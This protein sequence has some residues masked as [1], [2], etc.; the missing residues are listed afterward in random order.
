MRRGR[1]GDGRRRS[2]RT[3]AGVDVERDDR[4]RRRPTRSAIAVALPPGAAATSAIRSPGSRREHRRPRPGSPWSCGVARPSAHRG[5][6][7]G[8]ADAAAR[9]PRRG[10]ARPARPRPRRR[11]ARSASAPTVIRRGSG[12]RVTAGGSFMALERG[13]RVVGAEL[14]GEPRDEPVGVRERDRVVAPARATAA[15]AGVSARSSAF[16][17]PAR[18][19][20][21]RPDRVDG[22][23]HRRVRRRAVRAAGTRRAAARR[24]P[25]GRAASSG[26]LDARGRAGRRAGAATRTRA[27]DELG[28]ERAVAVGEVASAQHRREHDVRVRA[29]LD[30]HERVERDDARG[31]VLAHVPSS[32]ARSRAEQRIG[33]ASTGQP[34]V[35]VHRPRALG[36]HLDRARARP[37]RWRRARRRTTVPGSASMHADS[38]RARQHL[39]PRAVDR[40]STRPGAGSRRARRARARRPDCVRV[41]PELVDGRACRRRWARPACGSGVAVGTAGSVRDEQLGAELDEP[42]AQLARGL[43]APIGV[44]S[45]ANTG[46]VSRP[47]ERHDAHAG[48]GVAG[49]DRPLDRRRAAP[50]RQQREVHVHE[51]VRHRL[52]QRRAAAAGRTRRPR[53]ASAPR[54]RAPRRRPRATCSGVRTGEPERLGR[55]SCTGLGLGSPPRPRRRSGWVTTSAMSWPA[56]ASASSGGTASAGVPKKTSRTV[57]AALRAAVVAVGA[58]VRAA[59]PQLAARAARAAPRLRTSGSSRSSSSTPSRWSISCWIMRASSSS[60][61]RTT[62]LP[63]RSRPRIVTTLR[64]HDLEAAARAPTGSPRRRAPRRRARRSRG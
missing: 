17:K 30:A 2:M 32:R 15:A 49:E 13:T 61:S 46:P 54:R 64:P 33:R 52:E 56:R 37:R 41:E 25:A 10:P 43:V 60:P 28:G 11:A 14:V 1:C 26:A 12:R 20:R 57:G 6:R 47:L 16:T 7:A 27:V 24:A 9:R 48:L 59:A 42:G 21:A 36:L 5:R 23:R 34:G 62:S 4:R 3:P 40:W 22:R 50:A 51:P 44:R 58:G 55:G 18:T 45:R 38:G 35:G 29:V 31:D 39:Q 53:R 63:S 19:R 8:I